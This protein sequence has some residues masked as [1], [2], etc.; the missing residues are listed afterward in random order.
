MKKIYSFAIATAVSLT[1]FANT[2]VSK[3]A[4]LE[5]V[6]SELKIRTAAER[7]LDRPSKTTKEVTDYDKITWKSIGEGKYVAS[8]VADYYTASAEPT[9]VEVF[10][11]DGQPGIYKAVGTWSDIVKTGNAYI[12][13][14]A[15]NKECIKVP[16]TFT[17]I[18]DNVD[19]D[20]YIASQTWVLSQQYSDDAIIA[21]APDILPVYDDASITI[22]FPAKSLVLRWPEAPA[23]S[24]YGTDPSKYYVGESQGALILPGGTY[25]EPWQLFG[26]ATI[27]GDLYFSSFGKTPSDYKVEVYQSTSNPA[28]LRVKNAIQGLYDALNFNAAAPDFDFDTT[29]PENVSLEPTSLLINGGTDGVYYAL[30]YNQNLQDPST[31]PAAFRSTFTN[32]DNDAVIAIPNKGLFLWPSAT[33]NLYYANTTAV[34][35]SI[36]KT[37]GVEEITEVEGDDAPVEYYNLQ[38]IRVNNPTSGIYIVRQG[39]KVSKVLVK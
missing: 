12:I 7:T 39:A 19:G 4:N 9:T 27:S 32:N 15:S 38:G 36:K 16:Y 25:V 37:S 31:C 35:I 22:T 17:G 5:S 14:D 1:A 23:D 30:T 20:T 6:Q 33:T 24:Q 18:K 13:V 3:V 21:G 26:E 34:N 10:E 8:V 2:N 29:D 28:I 11:A